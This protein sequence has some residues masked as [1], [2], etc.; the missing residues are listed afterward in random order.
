MNC[1]LQ[2]SSKECLV[3]QHNKLAKEER[4]TLANGEIMSS[5]K[6]V[7]KGHI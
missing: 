2:V 4:S 6:G 7:G 3:S 5:C 1:K